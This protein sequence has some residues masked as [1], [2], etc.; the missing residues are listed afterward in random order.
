MAVNLAHY[1]PR[2][3]DAFISLNQ[4]W[5][6]QHW[7]L[8]SSDHKALGNPHGNIIDIGGYIAIASIDSPVIG[9]ITLLKIY[10]DRYEL[11][12]MAVEDG[13]KGKGIA[14][15]LCKYVI[16]KAREL[17]GKRHYLEGNTVLTPAIN[18]SKIEIRRNQ[19]A[20]FIL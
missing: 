17:G 1:Q 5:I 2:D 12:K 9:T 4:A 13:E 16:R 6:E 11:A 3:K 14:L 19:L 15:L 20:I 18:I 7:E 10:D 8:E